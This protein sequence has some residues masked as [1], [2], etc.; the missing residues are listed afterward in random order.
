MIIARIVQNTTNST[1]TLLSVIPIIVGVFVIVYEDVQLTIESLVL[2]IIG[3]ILAALKVVVTNLY[4]VE[5]QL[6]PMT[7]LSKLLPMA[8][9]VMFL[10]AVINGELQA[11]LLVYKEISITTYFWILFSAIMSFALNWTNFLANKN[12]SPL[13]MSILGNLKQVILVVFSVV[14]FHSTITGTSSIGIVIATVGLTFY[15]YLK[16]TKR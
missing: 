14:L 10:M 15:S 5:Y 8:S 9:I 6:H 2:L 1:L 13:T 11:F 3:N 16:V 12:T 4:L 7:M